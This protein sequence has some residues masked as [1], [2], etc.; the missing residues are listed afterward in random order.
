[1]IS[2]D[3]LPGVSDAASTKNKYFGD[4]WEERLLSYCFNKACFK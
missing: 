3:A 1:M 4:I 2:H